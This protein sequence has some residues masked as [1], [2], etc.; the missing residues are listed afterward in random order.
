GYFAIDTETTGL[1]PQ[2]AELVGICLSTEIG[3]G[4]RIPVGHQQPGDLLGGGGLVEGQLPIGFVLE[5][6]KRVLEDP[7]ILKIGQNVKYDMEIFARYGVTMMPIDDTMLISYALDGPRYN[8]LDVLADHWLDHKTI[9]YAELAGTGKAQKS[10][11]Q[12]DIAAAARYAA[13]GPDST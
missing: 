7:A 4:C 13:Q 1:D 12:H 6:L 9:T 2:M 8:G 11:D 3:A 5:A 10:F